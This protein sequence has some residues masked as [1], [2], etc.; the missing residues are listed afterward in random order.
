LQLYGLTGDLI[1][2]SLLTAGGLALGGPAQASVLRTFEANAAVSRAVVVASATAVALGAV[3]KIFHSTPYARWLFA[4][5]LGGGLF[6][7]LTR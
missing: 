3:W 2:G 1:R 5:G 7:A 6:V 4:V